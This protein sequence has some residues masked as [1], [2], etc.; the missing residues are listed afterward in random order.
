[1]NN[2]LLNLK[3]GLLNTAGRAGYTAKFFQTPPVERIFAS[4]QT[5]ALAFIYL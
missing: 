1:M 3:L 5:P 2:P 4:S